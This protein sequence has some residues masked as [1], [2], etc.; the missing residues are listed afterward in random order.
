MQKWEKMNEKCG[1]RITGQKTVRTTMSKSYVRSYPSTKD[2][3]LKVLMDP[4]RQ[5]YFK[6]TRWFPLLSHN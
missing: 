5:K 3:L 1:W 6:Y 4:T 2:P